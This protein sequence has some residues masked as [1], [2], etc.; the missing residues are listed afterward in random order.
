MRPLVLALAALALVPAA[1]AAMATGQSPDCRRFCMSVEPRSGPEG[2]VFRFEGRRWRPERR[3]TV[4]YGVYCRPGEACPAIALMAHLR[5]N[6]RGRFTFRL[7]ADGDWTDDDE[8]TRIRSGAH[9]TFRQRARGRTVAR[10][11]RYEVTVP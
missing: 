11:P 2:S 3:V 8:H 4:H 5:T 10:T 1:V 9:P 6:E 7:R